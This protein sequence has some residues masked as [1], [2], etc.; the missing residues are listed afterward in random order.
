MG[1][2]FVSILNYLLSLLYGDIIE[3]DKM[4]FRALCVTKRKQ[5]I[6]FDFSDKQKCRIQYKQR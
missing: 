4:L 5:L 3:G 2:H 1:R 6:H